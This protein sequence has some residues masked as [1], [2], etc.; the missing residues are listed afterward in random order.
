MSQILFRGENGYCLFVK[1]RRGDA[2]DKELRDFL[3]GGSIYHT[4]ERQ[5]ATECR[6][7]ITRKRFQVRIQ[8]RRALGCAARIV[9]LDDHCSGL[10]EFRRQA[11][12]CFQVHVIIVGELLALEL[13]RRCET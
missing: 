10:S 3:R 7:G 1:A 12:C 6:N 9:V 8:E 11:P 13:S 2:L 5:Y 4:V